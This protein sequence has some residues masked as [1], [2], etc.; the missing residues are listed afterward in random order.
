MRY[1][2]YGMKH[3]P[4]GIGCQPTGFIAYLD[5][6]IDR[7]A[8]KNDISLSAYHDVIA[9]KDKLDDVDIYDYELEFLGELE[10]WM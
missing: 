3:R 4:R 7:W 6:V 8:N 2:I 10:E 1:Y 5:R 9:Y